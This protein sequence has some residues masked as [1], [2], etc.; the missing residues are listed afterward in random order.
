MVDIDNAPLTYI[1]PSLIQGQGLFA[2][3]DFKKGDIILDYRP[4]K[5]TF[6]EIEWRFLDQYQIDHNW[7]IPI[8]DDRCLTSNPSS[9]I[10][11]INHSKNPTGD[12]LI[13]DLLIL[14]SRDLNKDEEITIDYRLEYRPTRKAWPNWV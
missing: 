8:D 3:I 9:K 13:K 10:I 5:E 12:W 11:Y 2:S 6:K 1:R 4:W 14:A 7:F